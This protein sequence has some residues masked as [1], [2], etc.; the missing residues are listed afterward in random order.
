MSQLSL[1]WFGD[2][3]D[4]DDGP[5]EDVVPPSAIL[6]LLRPQE[7]PEPP[8]EPVR[9]LDTPY[10]EDPLAQALV[11][12]KGPMTCRE[13]ATVY[14][15]SRQLIDQVEKR[16]LRKLRDLYATRPEL[17]DELLLILRGAANRRGPDED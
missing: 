5:T 12:G 17:R 6:A 10:T 9:S 13:V 16:A 11:N 2:D 14:G 8:A 3:E 15:C 7:A 1:R 4:G